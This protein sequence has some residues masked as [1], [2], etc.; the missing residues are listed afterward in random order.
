MSK[1]KENIKL[2]NIEL[3]INLNQFTSV[4]LVSSLVNSLSKKVGNLG[5]NTVNIRNNVDIAL[6]NKDNIKIFNILKG[7]CLNEIY[8]F[9]NKLNNIN[10]T[11]QNINNILKIFSTIITVLS[12]FPLTG[13]ISKVINNAQKIVDGLNVLIKIIIPLINSLLNELNYEKSRLNIEGENLKLLSSNPSKLGLVEGADY[14]GFQFYI[15]E[16]NNPQY[17]VDKK[18]KRRYAV[19]VDKK[20]VERIRSDFSYTLNPDVLIEQIKLEIDIQNIKS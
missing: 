10:N 9:E 18:Y 4:D 19:A 14:K 2:S 11:V 20:G 17:L 12:K 7:G 13:P 6:E 15:K 3:N 8:S 1:I 16:D 5:L